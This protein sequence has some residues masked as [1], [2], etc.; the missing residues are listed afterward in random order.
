[1]YQLILLGAFI[2]A[3]IL[4]SIFY[5]ARKGIS[6]ADHVWEVF[7][8]LLFFYAPASIYGALKETVDINAPLD[9]RIAMGA[10]LCVAILYIFLS[11]YEESQLRDEIKELTDKNEKLNYSYEQLDK[12][13]ESFRSK[14]QQANEKK[15][16]ATIEK[17]VKEFQSDAYEIDCLPDCISYL[18]DERGYYPTAKDWTVETDFD[19]EAIDCIQWCASD[20]IEW[21]KNNPQSANVWCQ[22]MQIY[23]GTIDWLLENGY[24]TQYEAES[25]CQ[26]LYR[27][28]RY[29]S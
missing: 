24:I 27:Q 18:K 17:F 23:R 20:A 16:F 15:L 2:V 5:P 1:M 9:A 28:M 25:D 29:N 7:Y 11:N 4:F 8:F 13:F 3:W 10:W 6:K 22:W 12:D 19:K 26:R 21:G 14:H